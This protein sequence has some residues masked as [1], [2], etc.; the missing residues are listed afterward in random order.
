MIIC[1]IINNGVNIDLESLESIFILVINKLINIFGG[2]YEK[3]KNRA[4]FW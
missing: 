1:L 4:K 2:E 3:S